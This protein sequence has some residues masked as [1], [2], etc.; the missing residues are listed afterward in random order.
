MTAEQIELGRGARPTVEY[1]RDG[2]NYT[3]IISAPGMPERRQTFQLDVE[4]DEV[5][6]GGRRVK[7]LSCIAYYSSAYHHH[8]IA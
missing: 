6:L 7:V 5:A 8:H 1:I 2:D 3:C 4:I